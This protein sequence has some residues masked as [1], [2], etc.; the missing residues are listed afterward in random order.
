MTLLS[1]MFT[2]DCCCSETLNHGLNHG[3]F[4]S[5]F[6]LFLCKYVLNWI[7]NS[8]LKSRVLYC[9]SFW[10]LF[11][12][13]QANLSEASS[14]L[15]ALTAVLSRSSLVFT[16]LGSI[17]LL[18]WFNWIMVSFV[19]GGCPPILVKMQNLCLWCPMS[20]SSYLMQGYAFKI[21]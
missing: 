3:L 8:G 4:L 14:F 16:L 5:L 7:R 13:V 9:L 18:A 21:L 11:L 20:R 15:S 17:T 2:M 1:G 12:D 10:F 19:G 6:K